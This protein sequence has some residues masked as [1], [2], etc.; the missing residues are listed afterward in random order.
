MARPEKHTVEY[1]P[2]IVKDGKTLF[3]LESQWGAAGTGVFTNVMRF[4]CSTPDHHYCIED[5]GDR[6]FFF[7]RIHIDEE[8]GMK[9]LE[10]MSKTG[11]IDSGFFRRKLI[12]YSQDL[13]DSLAEAYRKRLNPIIAKESIIN[14]YGLTAE[15]TYKSAEE[16]NEPPEKGGN[17]PQT[18]LNQTKLKKKEPQSDEEWLKALE[19]NPVYRGLE[20]RTLY[21]KMLVWCEN[22]GKKPTR[23]RFVNWL[24]REEKPMNVAGGN[25]NGNGHQRGARGPWIQQREADPIPE[26]K[27]DPTPDVSE[28]EREAA[29]QRIRA[30]TEGI[31]KNPIH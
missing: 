29:L 27:G 19:E 14:I 28:Q 15:G 25:G 26:Y 9:M 7:S 2:F 4:L 23:R 30:L 5:P 31:G 6:L 18:K 3:V 24:N 13:V 11:K 16:T 12:I 22:N 20:V 21:G 10:A 8:T 1:F 17:K